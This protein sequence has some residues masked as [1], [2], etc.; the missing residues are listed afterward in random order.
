MRTI[1]EIHGHDTCR[2]VRCKMHQ[3]T[4]GGLRYIWGIADEIT[5]YDYFFCQFCLA[6][7]ARKLYQDEAPEGAKSNAVL[8]PDNTK[9]IQ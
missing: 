4:Y 2:N 3:F 7:V 6:G 9:I 8:L 5:Y 1:A